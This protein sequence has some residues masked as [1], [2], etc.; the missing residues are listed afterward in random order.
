MGKRAAPTNLSH[1]RMPFL[2][3]LVIALGAGLLVALAAWLMPLPAQGR[4]AA[5][6]AAGESVGR[7]LR[8]RERLLR[9]LRTRFD[10]AAATG[11]ALTVGALFIVSAGIVLGLLAY[12]VRTESGLH[13][14]DVSAGQWGVDH[15][16][17]LSTDL[18]QLTTHLGDTVVVASL[19]VVLAIVESVRRPNRWLV[20]YLGLV[21]IGQ[22]LLTNGLKE[23]LDRVRPAFNP[24]AATLGP[25]FP[26]GHTAAAAAFYAAA[27]LV[28]GR[29]R[30][31]LP[32]ALLAGGAAA[33]AVA[34]ACTRVL[35]GVHW[36]T[37]VVGGLALGWAWFALCSIAF[38][39]RL[40]RFGVAAED[41]LRAAPQAAPGRARESSQAS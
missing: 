15:A 4:H 41:A 29:G 22:N 24:V 31:P 28:L 37:D 12:L 33:L 2:A 21:V 16:T 11:L 14:V 9:S 35:L 13:R 36:L 40:L 8:K 38:G 7:A 18:L 17:E 30:G 32:R 5:S 10:P 34:V 26:S 19:A 20:P 27:A 39:G 23:V 25:S 3:L 1:S 6:R